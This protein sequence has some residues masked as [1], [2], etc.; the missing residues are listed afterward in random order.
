MKAIRKIVCPTDFSEYSDA[1]VDVAVGFARKFGARLDFVHVFQSP[2]FT[3]I[4]DSS[5]STASRAI[6]ILRDRARDQMKTL[7]THVSEQGVAAEPVELEGTA[8]ERIV[9]LS[10]DADLVVMGT[11]GRTG[12]RRLLLGSVAERVVRRAQ[13]PVLTV[14]R[15][16]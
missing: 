9:E 13:C 10:R 3:T 16:A 5:Q 6:E 14:P 8:D 12:L 15:A 1:A 11:H 4:D 7:L 2:H